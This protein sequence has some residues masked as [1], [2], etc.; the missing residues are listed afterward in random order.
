MA[1]ILSAG[2]TSATAMVHTADTSGVLQLASNNGTVGVTLDTSQNVGIGNTSPAV[3]LHIGSGSTTP[4][5][6]FGATSNGYDIG[7]NNSSGYFIQNATQASPYNQ[8]IWQQSGTE[9]VRINTY[10]IGLGGTNPASGMGIAFPVNQSASSDANTLDDYEEGTFTPVITGSGS[11][12]T[13]VYGQQSGVYTKVGNWVYASMQMGLTSRSGGTGNWNISLPFTSLNDSLY[14]GGY[15]G[16]I[17]GFSHSGSYNQWGARIPTGNNKGELWE[18][19]GTGGN[20]NTV[21]I[22]Q[23]GAGQCY[24]TISYM[25]RVA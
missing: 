5:I 11:N 23:Q 21:G 9:S 13:I 7:R 12:P 20:D 3:P 6:R 10:G 24:L 2:T 22:T 25:Y 14:Y 16:T 15:I 19:S 17:Y 1:S 4:T 8:F 18:F